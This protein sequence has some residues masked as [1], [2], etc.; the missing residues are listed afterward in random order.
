MNYKTI[1]LDTDKRHF[2]FGDIHGRYDTMMKLLEEINYD[3]SSDVLYS[4]GDLIDRGPKSVEVVKFWMKHPDRHVIRGNH[5]QMLV[6][7]SYWRDVW[8]HP[9]NGG[10]DTLRSLEKHGLDEKWLAEFCEDLPLV[11]NVGEEDDKDAFRLVH[12]EQPPA[13]SDELLFNYLDETNSLDAGESILL[14]GRDTISRAL[15]DLDVAFDSGFTRTRNIFSGHTP[16]KE[17]IVVNNVLWNKCSWIDTA[18][19]GTMSCVNPIG[20]HEIHST[21]IIDKRVY[22]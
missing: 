10:P 20:E 2:I 12:A 5:E 11:L 13:W 4:V 6:N 16:T 17:V 8:L 21:P 3:A 14:W 22:E 19:G 1:K 15:H 7:P 18:R 9:P